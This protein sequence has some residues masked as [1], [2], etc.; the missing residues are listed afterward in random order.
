MTARVRI[1]SDFIGMRLAVYIAD[2]FGDS[3]RYHQPDGT[4]LTV[5]KDVIPPADLEPT[6]T[7]QEEHARALLDQ[8]VTYFNGGENTRTLRRDYDAERA[9]VDRLIEH[10][11]GVI[12][13]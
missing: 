11:V 13:D 6:L 4:V 2:D 10:L 1:A 5:P 9:R 12:H 7:L 3:Y 8:L